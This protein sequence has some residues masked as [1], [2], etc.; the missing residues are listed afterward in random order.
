MSGPFGILPAMGDVT[1]L[2]AVRASLQENNRALF[3][4]YLREEF[5]AE[6][7]VPGNQDVVFA[8]PASRAVVRDC[9]AA[10]G[11]AVSL[12]EPPKVLLEAWIYL[13]MEPGNWASYWLDHP[14][15]YDLLTRHFSP[16][17]H[18]YIRA[19]STGDRHAAAR[20]WTATRWANELNRQM[21]R[22]RAQSD[23]MARD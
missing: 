6:H 10:Y 1:D 21:N 23:R 19:I 8:R 12:E 2:S 11:A 18:A 14:N 9:F 4:K 3:L 7:L 17:E 22:W 13:S 20:L 16:H 5:P 15:T